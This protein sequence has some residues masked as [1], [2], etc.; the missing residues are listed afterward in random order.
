MKKIL[1]KIV[2]LSTLM[3]LPFSSAY[4]VYTLALFPTANSSD[5]T[6]YSFENAGTNVSDEMIVYASV[7]S[8]EWA[9]YSF[10]VGENNART[11]SSVTAGLSSLGTS[12][13]GVFSVNIYSSQSDKDNY[14][15]HSFTA[16]DD[17][18]YIYGMACWIQPITSDCVAGQPSSAGSHVF[19]GTGNEYAFTFSVATVNAS[20]KILKSSDGA[21]WSWD[22]GQVG[23]P[24]SG[25]VLNAGSG[26]GGGGAGDCYLDLPGLKSGD[27]VTLNLQKN[28]AVYT[29]SASFIPTPELTQVGDGCNTLIFRLGA[30][31]ATK[32]TPVFTLN[33]TS[34]SFTSNL[35]EV[36]NPVRGRQ[37]VM[38]GCFSDLSGAKGTLVT[39][40]SVLPDLVEMP[41]VSV[42]A[43]N[44]GTAPV[45]TLE[46]PVAGVS[47]TWK[48]NGSVVTPSGSTYTVPAPEAGV[49]Y[50]MEV[51][52]DNGCT[53]QTSQPVSV[54]LRLY[55][56]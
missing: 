23:H 54:E 15:P 20:F 9:D 32:Y 31:D 8:S 34:V 18:N 14:F 24:S 21:S 39:E 35:Y 16:M 19:M 53:S 51:T 43:D 29:L 3:L 45:F 46:N 5:V 50:T 42:S 4:A 47:Y 1:Y 52:A 17:T 55:L 26:I 38:S 6:Y 27:K 10:W 12:A 2:V 37:Y 28:G 40:V 13:S 33:G 7:P 41:L 30:Y 49:T 11:S 48:L 44:C 25:T 36:V 56:L 22:A